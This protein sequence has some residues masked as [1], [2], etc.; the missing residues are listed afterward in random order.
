MSLFDRFRGKAGSNSY[1]LDSWPSAVMLMAQ[2]AFFPSEQE[3]LSR[4]EKAWGKAGSPKIVGTLREGATLLIQ[5][6]ALSYSIHCARQRYSNPWSQPLEIL[7][8]PWADHTSWM[9]VDLPNLR[10][11]ALFRDGSLGMMYKT[12]LVFIFLSWSG[13][14][15]GLVFPAERATVPNLG[16]L[17]ASINWC[18]Q[19]GLNMSFL[20]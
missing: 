18:R 6:D 3:I 5:C 15:L 10:N 8:R 20:D 17:A 2:P 19:A 13:N 7:Q 4:A 1:P 11:E 14:S 9:A 12:I 16:D